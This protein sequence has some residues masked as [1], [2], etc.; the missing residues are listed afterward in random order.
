MIR[1]AR[2]GSPGP[3]CGATPATADSD[4][5]PRQPSSTLPRCSPGM[6]ISARVIPLTL[7]L[8][9][10]SA[11]PA[12]AQSLASEEE[13]EQLLRNL[14]DGMRAG[15]SARVRSVFH[16]DARMLSVGVRPAD[17]A[18][19]LRRVSVD[20]FVR[21]VGAPRDEIWDERIR[22]VEVRV[23]ENL[24]TAWMKYWFYRGD[25]FSHCGVNAFQLVR[26]A[27]GWGVIQITDTR[28]RE[29]CADPP[30]A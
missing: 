23:D 9:C 11:L 1:D 8:L 18:A 2:R 4:S 26:G 29:G 3:A 15:D 30:E 5:D 10:A 28:R 13:V 17:G 12:Y 16:P 24:A 14:F 20:E 6:A 21:A 19:V 27:D 22:D 7:L 25:A